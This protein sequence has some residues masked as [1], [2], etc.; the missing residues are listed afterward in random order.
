VPVES[1]T[2]KLDLH[3]AIEEVR[4]GLHAKVEYN[5]ALFKAV[6]IDRLLERF[7]VLLEC[8]VTSPELPIAAL[9]LLSPV[10]RQHVLEHWNATEQADAQQM[11]LHQLF[12][13]QVA[14]VPDALALVCEGNHLTYRELNRRANQ[15]ARYLRGIG[16]GPEVLVGLC[17]ERSLAFVTAWLGILKAGGVYLPLDPSYPAERLAFM[18]EDA[19][20]SVLITQ[21]QWQNASL[22][23]NETRRVSLDAV[24]KAAAQEKGDNLLEE[25]APENAAYVIYTSGSTGRP[26]GTLVTYRGLRNLTY[27]LNQAFELRPTDRVLQFASMN[28]DASLFEMVMTLSMGAPLYLSA[29]GVSHPGQ[30]LADVLRE[31]AITTVALVP[32]VLSALPEGDYASLTTVIAGGEVCP[33]ELVARWVNG[34]RFFN[35]YG[36]TEATVWATVAECYEGTAKLAIGRPISNVQVYILDAHLEPVPIGFP[37]E[38]YI[39]GVGVARGYINRADLTAERFLPHPFS[40]EGGERVYRTGDRARYLSDGA[41]EFLGRIDQQVKIR[42]FRIELQEIEAVLEICPSVQ[43]AVLLAR[44]NDAGQQHL[45]AYIVPDEGTHVLPDTL[46]AFLKERL[47]DYMIPALFLFIHALPLTPNGKLDRQA[48]PEPES[49]RP[50]LET[51]FVVPGTPAEHALAEI[52]AQVL[53][54]E[55]VGIHDDFFDLGGD[56]MLSIQMLAMAQEKGLEISF[57]QLFQYKTIHQIV[58]VI[59]GAASGPSASRTKQPFQLIAPGDRQRIPEGV[60]DAY[61]LT[62]LQA[63]MIFHDEQSP[64]AVL[65]HDIGSFHMHAPYDLQQL[66]T[67]LQQLIRRHS[68]LRT[69]F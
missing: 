27:A 10:E 62:M 32:S 13:A 25:P 34:R 40:K 11:N 15:L 48:L 55:R 52:W 42:G 51:A 16:A 12:E 53:E 1:G 18:L 66:H 29:R 4:E 45:V 33:S 59:D 37:G 26:K 41:I 9:P 68:I 30:A 28:F 39:G 7:Q 56:S 61:P 58:Q 57:Q 69:S 6:T 14:R 38:L 44:E 2:A 43:S 23:P 63:G 31:Q 64:D 5:T 22:V 49:T 67:A 50:E 21:E 24:W 46:R 20:V 35:V 3:V 19:R 47:P 65:Y 60:E 8:I 17:A 36:P 54:V